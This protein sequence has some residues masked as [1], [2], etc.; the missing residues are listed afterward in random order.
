MQSDVAARVT[1][2]L[3]LELLPDSAPSVG[4]TL[5][6]AAYQSYLKGRFHWNNRGEEGLDEALAFFTSVIDQEPA[7]G[8]GHAALAR[9]RI[10][11]AEGYRDMPRL[12]LTRAQEHAARALALDPDLSDAH[13]ATGDVERLLHWNWVAAAEAYARALHLNPSNESALRSYGLLLA[14]LERPDEARREVDQAC[15]LDPLCVIATLCSVWVRYSHGDYEYAIERCR[16]TIDM[17]PERVAAH[18]LLAAAL[19]QTGRHRDALV[20]FEAGVRLAPEDPVALAW[21]AHARAVT[22]E[23]AE[24]VAIVHRIRSLPRYAPPYHLALAYCG[25]GD[26]DAAFLALD[27]AC[28]DRDPMVTNLTIEPRFEPLRRDP[29]YED[30]CARLRLDQRLTR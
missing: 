2:A 12:E 6:P 5:A 3:A 14:A 24:A 25:L 9:A 26:A 29:R 27:T 28:A 4:Q 13:L 15:E 1:R 8:A 16:H 19:L 18:R 22:G 11:A 17:D 10:A 7:F 23:T 20:S 30:L 21:L